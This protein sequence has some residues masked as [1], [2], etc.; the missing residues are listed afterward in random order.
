MF[1]KD[2]PA[3]RL[4]QQIRD[5]A[6]RFAVT[7]PSQGQSDARPAI[8]A[9][10]RAGHRPAAAQGAARRVRQPG[11][12]APRISRRADGASSARKPPTPCSDTSP[13]RGDKPVILS[14][15]LLPDLDVPALIIAFL[16]LLFSLTVHEAAHAWSA[17]RLGDDTAKRLGRVSLNPVVHTDPIGTLLLPL[18]AMVSG[19][20]IIGWAK[21]T[22]VN[23]RNLQASATRSHSGDRRG[24]GQQP[25]HRRRRRGCAARRRR[26]RPAD[27]LDLLVLRRR[28]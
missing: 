5:E 21:P 18:I 4:V 17:S 11:G 19:A 14:T 26:R 24:T 27:W 13:G 23:T 7:L 10:Q 20:P 12:R 1:A 16:V 28:R 8:G 2:D 9:R 6:H 25:D 22:P 15:P 3:L